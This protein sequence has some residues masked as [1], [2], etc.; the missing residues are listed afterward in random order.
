MIK[1]MF[2]EVFDLSNQLQEKN[3]R[4]S[5]NE[6]S[7][8]D[9]SIGTFEEYV[10]QEKQHFDREIPVEK[11]EKIKNLYISKDEIKKENL[12]F[13]LYLFHLTHTSPIEFDENYKPLPLKENEVYEYGAV[14]SLE[15]ESGYY[16]IS[17]VFG[18]VEDD[19][20]LAKEKYNA[21]KIKVENSSEEQLLD[22]IKNEILK[23]INQ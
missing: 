7:K 18:G 11:K 1:D 10:E 2:K 23:Q 20:E 12:K 22:N 4:K 21:L 8:L 15:D 5:Y 19:E 16:N 14:V 3:Y 9:K 6:L 17:G 13:D